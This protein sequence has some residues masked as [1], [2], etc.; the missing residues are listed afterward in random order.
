[1]RDCFGWDCGSALVGSALVGSAGLRRRDCFLLL[2]GGGQRDCGIG[3]ARRDCF[4]LLVKEDCVWRIACVSS[5]VK[6]MNSES[7]L[8]GI[9][10]RQGLWACCGRGSRGL[11]RRR[12]RRIAKQGQGLVVRSGQRNPEAL[13]ETEKMGVGLRRGEGMQGGKGGLQRKEEDWKAE[14]ATFPPRGENRPQSMQSRQNSRKMCAILLRIR[15][16]DT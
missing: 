16:G 5:V 14:N 11:Q 7:G 1:M 2:R 12:E 10:N 6:K 8:R 13:R 15:G 4:L 9:A 3:I